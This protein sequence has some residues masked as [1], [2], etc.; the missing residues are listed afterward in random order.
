VPVTR[1]GNAF[2][3]IP[4]GSLEGIEAVIDKDNCG[5]LLANQLEADGFVILTDGGGIFEN[6]GKPNQREMEKASAQYL[7][8]TGA[9]KRFPGSMGPKI[10]AAIRFVE[11]SSK[12]GAFAAI[13]DLSDA[14]DIL[15]GKEGTLVLK[16]VPGG[17][18]WREKAFEVDAMKGKLSKL[19]VKVPRNP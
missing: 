19:A 1:M 4:A 13:G 5:A 11:Q 7:R 18:I 17:V 3:T 16:E 12:P 2:A 9:G 14:S 6:F 10:A 8:E 15:E